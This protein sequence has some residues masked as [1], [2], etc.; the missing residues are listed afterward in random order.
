M[1]TPAPIAETARFVVEVT[2][3]FGCAILTP[4]TFVGPKGYARAEG[5][6]AGLVADG[7]YS[8][9]RCAVIAATI[10]PAAAGR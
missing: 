1:Q 6:A 7:W 10:K 2:D 5:Y 8:G 3:L 9:R 4:Q